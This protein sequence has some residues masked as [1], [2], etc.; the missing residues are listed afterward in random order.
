MATKSGKVLTAQL[1]RD[2]TEQFFAGQFYCNLN[3][4][5]DIEDG[6]AQVL[7]KFYCPI[8]LDGLRK[9]TLSVAKRLATHQ[10]DLSLNGISDLSEEAA[11]AL[12]RHPGEL[13]LQGLKDIPVGVAKALASHEY[14]LYLNGLSNLDAATAS[15]LAAHKGGCLAL[16]GIEKLS[17]EAAAAISEYKGELLLGMQSLP[18]K[19]AQILGN[20]EGTLGLFF[21]ESLSEK[22]AEH[23]ANNQ[24][25][26]LLDSLTSLSGPVATALSKHEGNLSLGGL[27]ELSEAEAAI[28]S[29]HHGGLSF[30]GLETLSIGAM[31]I[32]AEHEGDLSLDGLENFPNE[33]FDI[34]SRHGGKVSV[35]MLTDIESVAAGEDDDDREFIACVEYDLKGEMSYNGAAIMTRAAIRRLIDALSKDAT[36]QMPNTPEHFEEELHL[37]E[38]K[39]AFRIC[40]P[41]PQDVKAM[42]RIFGETVGD[43]SLFDCVI[44]AE[45]RSEDHEEDDED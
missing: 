24:G 25:D 34:F 3:E 36:I 44:E 43:T 18:D 9:L 30:D 31:R 32:L 45:P 35:S 17:D 2:L 29:K 1:A 13:K 38:L 10:G 42:R 22:A 39:D 4:Y 12:A 37:S 40:S 6:A 7:S 41:W 26:L 28:L 27:S 19:T 16:C 20:H 11:C 8:C 21:V 15:G 5:T 33:G 14:S 23:L